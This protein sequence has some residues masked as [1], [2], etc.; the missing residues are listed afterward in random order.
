MI[1]FDKMI[2]HIGVPKSAT[3]TL[4]FQ[5][6]NRH[7]GINYFGKP[8]WCE[9]VGLDKSVEFHHAISRIWQKDSLDYDASIDGEILSRLIEERSIHGSVNLLSEEGLTNAGFVDR[10]IVAE[11]LKNVLKA[12]KIILTIRNQKTALISLYNWYYTRTIVNLSFDSWI[13]SMFCEDYYRGGKRN[14]PFRQFEY[15][16]LINVYDG[17]FGKENVLVIPIELLQ[18]D[19]EHFS[20]LLSEFIGIETEETSNLLSCAKRENTS[21]GYISTK[22]QRTIHKARN[23]YFNYYLSHK[24][25]DQ[26]GHH[27]FSGVVPSLFNSIVQPIDAKPQRSSLSAINSINEYFS[28][29]NKNLVDRGRVDIEKYDY[30]IF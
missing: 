12:K 21:S 24:K 17:L 29:G 30:P 7:S 15:D 27:Y 6:F 13:S 9:R 3:S 14:F 10:K 4:Q 19:L 8:Y 25:C 11:R 16:K 28:K 18:A 2:V 1:I 22:I 23:L 5:Y 26:M 20:S